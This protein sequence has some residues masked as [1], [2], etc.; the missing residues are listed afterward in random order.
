MCSPVG[1]KLNKQKV[2]RVKCQIQTE[3]GGSAAGQVPVPDSGGM[4]CVSMCKGVRCHVCSGL[5]CHANCSL[6]SQLDHGGLSGLTI[7]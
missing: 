6:Y 5:R 2:P 4:G 3:S 1:F 7:T